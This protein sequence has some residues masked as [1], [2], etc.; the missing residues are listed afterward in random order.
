MKLR[1]MVCDGEHKATD[2]KFPFTKWS[3]K[4]AMVNGKKEKVAYIEG[5]ICRKCILKD[6]RKKNA[7]KV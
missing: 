7:G 2:K 3:Q 6:L 1:C 4:E 5:H